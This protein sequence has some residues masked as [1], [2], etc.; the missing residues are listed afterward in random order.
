MVNRGYSG[1]EIDGGG[2][3]RLEIGRRKEIEDNDDMQQL[4]SRVYGEWM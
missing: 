1:R 2:R 4:H 3:R